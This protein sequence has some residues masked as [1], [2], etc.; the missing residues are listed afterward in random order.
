MSWVP[1]KDNLPAGVP[2][3]PR[4]R[5]SKIGFVLCAERGDKDLRRALK[6][7]LDIPLHDVP[8]ED[9]VEQSSVSRGLSHKLVEVTSG[10]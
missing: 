8:V 1:L 9:L 3:I 10:K 6:S 7:K 4:G 2:E 5:L